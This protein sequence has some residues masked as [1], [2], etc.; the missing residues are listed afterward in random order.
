MIRTDDDGRVKGLLSGPLQV[1][2]HRIEFDT[3]EYF[4]RRNRQGCYPYVQITFEVTNAVVHHHVPLL[5]NPFG[6][7][8]YR[9]S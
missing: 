1:G 2:I 5:L 4:R 8:T 7:S 9:G 3:G 6:F